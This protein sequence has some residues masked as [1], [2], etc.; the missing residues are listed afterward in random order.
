MVRDNTQFLTV[1]KCVNTT[2]TNILVDKE[3]ASFSGAALYVLE[4]HKF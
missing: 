3:K 1:S 2:N 4:R